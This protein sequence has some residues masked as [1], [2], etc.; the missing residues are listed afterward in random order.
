M[1]VA[2]A[3]S[4][5]ALAR[6]LGKAGEDAAGISKNTERIPSLTG[7]ADFRVPDA[8]SHEEGIIGEVK[9]VERL[10]FTAQLKD[11]VAYAQ[12]NGYEFQL[13]I[14]SDTY[15]STSLRNAVADGTVVLKKLK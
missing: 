8:L 1:V 15:L 10:S 5:T 13:T 9:N 4:P 11:Y 14:R 6:T 2:R 12:Q 7:T 3:P